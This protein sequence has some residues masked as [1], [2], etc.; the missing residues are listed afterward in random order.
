MYVCLCI[1]KGGGKRHNID[2]VQRAIMVTRVRLELSYRLPL[3]LI[4]ELSGGPL[5]L[6]HECTD[7]PVAIPG[8]VKD[9][10]EHKEQDDY[11]HKFYTEI[12]YLVVFVFSMGNPAICPDVRHLYQPPSLLPSGRGFFDANSAKYN[13]NLRGTNLKKKYKWTNHFA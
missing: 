2:V 10:Y 6:L 12:I 13:L 3:Q 4:V 1:R 7:E 5:H 8:V 11:A 9:V